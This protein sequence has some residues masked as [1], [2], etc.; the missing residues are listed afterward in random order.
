MGGNRCGVEPGEPALALARKIADASHLSFA[1][2][3]AYHGSAQHLRSWEERQKAI[4]GAVETAALTR[5]VLSANGIA[6]DNITGAGTGTFEFEAASGVY[7]ELQSGS[8]LS[9]HAAYGRN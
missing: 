3:Q 5:D 9:T 8:S 6:C 2:L 1:G 7:T 4:A